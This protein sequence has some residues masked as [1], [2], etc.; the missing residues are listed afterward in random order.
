M[1]A[2]FE[3]GTKYQSRNSRKDI[4]T[5]VDILKTYNS[6][7]ELVQIRYVTTHSFLG[8]TVK[9]S[10]VVATTIAMGLITCCCYSFDHPPC[11]MHPQATKGA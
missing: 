3:I 5:V 6:Q 11:A 4:C 8:Q 1:E 7:G 10:D 2:Q 9:N